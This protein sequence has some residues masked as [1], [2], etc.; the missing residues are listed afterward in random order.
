MVK[1]LGI[2]MY[3]GNVKL[4]IAEFIDQIKNSTSAK[5]NH[6]IS[7][8]DAHCLVEANLNTSFSSILS[9]FHYVLPDGLPSVW[10]GR[11][12]GAKQMTRCTGADTFQTFMEVAANEP[13]NHFFCGGKE[14][15]AAR[16]KNNC[17]TR[18]NNH[19]IVGTYTPP[20]KPLTELEWENL[21]NEINASGAQV[22]WIGLS[23]PKQEAFA[24]ALSKRVNVDY[25]LTVGAVF[26]FFTGE[27]KRAPKWMQ[28]NGLEWLFRLLQEPVR[29][30]PRYGKVVP[31]FIYL[32][33]KEWLKAKFKK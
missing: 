22:V 17:E 10:V 9:N 32:N 31:M 23:S 30:F 25:I 12:K 7:V 19:H 16:L 28:E 24:L 14:G 6:L 8:A 15:I 20:F 4:L 1:V 21:A 33:C 18:F 5:K 11:Y 29:L 26:D 3:E 27:K 13:V 2:E